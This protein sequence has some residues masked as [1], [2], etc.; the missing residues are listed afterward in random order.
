[1]T[2]GAPKSSFPAGEPASGAQPVQVSRF[3]RETLEAYAS[4][5]VADD[6][7][8]T[9]LGLAGWSALPAR[10]EELRE[11]IDRHL[12][13]AA[14]VV[15]GEEIAEAIRQ[16]LQPLI[17][18]VSQIEASAQSTGRSEGSIERTR[19]DAFDDRTPTRELGLKPFSVV[20]VVG[21]DAEP[22]LQL[23]AQIDSRTAVIP[24]GD[25]RVLVRDLKLLRAQSRMIVIDVRRPH[26]LIDAVR[27]EPALLEGAVVVLWG[28]SRELEADLLRAFPEAR[29]VRCGPDASVDDLAAIVRLGTG[30]SVLGTR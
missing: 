7:L 6:V 11:L 3:I 8:R 27:S 25:S 16:R 24:V 29:I 2:A 9:A 28:A 26:S 5:S 4:E 18:V 1:M 13:Q 21:R 30:S 23:K 19:P 14:A 22:A 10:S 20:L 12:A 17:L 15:M